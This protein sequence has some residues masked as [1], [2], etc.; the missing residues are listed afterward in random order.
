MPLKLGELEVLSK[1][2]FFKVFDKSKSRPI[3]KMRMQDLLVFGS[4]QFPFNRSVSITTEKFQFCENKGT[5]MKQ[6]L[7]C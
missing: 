4:Q 1:K 2:L 5:R 7:S 3:E 6:K